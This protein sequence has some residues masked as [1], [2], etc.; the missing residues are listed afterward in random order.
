MHAH[1]RRADLCSKRGTQQHSGRVREGMHRKLNHDSAEL[2]KSSKYRPTSRLL[3]RLPEADDAAGDGS[4][5]WHDY[6]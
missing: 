1:K 2:R 4:L 3:Q 5:E 6:V